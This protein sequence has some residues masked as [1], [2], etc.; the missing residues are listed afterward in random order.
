VCQLSPPSKT[1]ETLHAPKIIKQ[2]INEYQRNYQGNIKLK[3]CANA[4]PGKI[5]YAI[6]V[7]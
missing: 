5:F 6:T 4:L 7:L 2:N 1:A 3:Q